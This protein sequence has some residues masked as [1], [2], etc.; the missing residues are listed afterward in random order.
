VMVSLGISV[1]GSEKKRTIHFDYRLKRG[2]DG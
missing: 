2:A 1:N